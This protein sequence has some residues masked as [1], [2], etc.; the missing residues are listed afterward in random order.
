MNATTAPTILIR[1]R[2]TGTETA[3]ETLAIKLLA[4][5]ETETTM[6]KKENATATPTA[7]QMVY[8][9]TYS[10]QTIKQSSHTFHSLVKIPA[11]QKVHAF[12]TSQ[13]K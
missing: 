6:R 7:A 5:A 3:G 4:A 1:N 8:Q 2:K 12:K 9:A 11:Q 13:H 10:A